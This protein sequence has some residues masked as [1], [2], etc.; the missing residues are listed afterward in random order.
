[1][2]PIAQLL[3]RSLASNLVKHILHQAEELHP[4]SNRTAKSVVDQEHTGGY[5]PGAPV[6][7][8]GSFWPGE[9]KQQCDPLA[10]GVENACRRRIFE[11]CFSGMPVNIP[12][13][14][15]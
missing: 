13:R 12:E 6:A 15:G 2:G 11:A 3:A 9:A 1:M 8:S 5:L 7:V 10:H 14:V 4:G